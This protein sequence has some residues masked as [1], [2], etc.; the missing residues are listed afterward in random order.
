MQNKLKRKESGLGVTYF[1][2]NLIRNRYFKERQQTQPTQ[3]LWGPIGSYSVCA[4]ICL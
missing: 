3:T 2:F 1:M 4:V